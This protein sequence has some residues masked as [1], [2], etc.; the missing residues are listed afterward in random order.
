[1][2]IKSSWGA[3]GSCS[4]WASAAPRPRVMVLGCGS[5]TDASRRVGDTVAEPIL[6]ELGKSGRVEAISRSH[7]QAAR[8]LER[9][10]RLLGCEEDSVACLAELTAASVLGGL[11]VKGR[12]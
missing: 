2:K 8:G 3:M 4:G 7:A 11:L 10:K 1:M 5:S 6:T 12:F 9:R